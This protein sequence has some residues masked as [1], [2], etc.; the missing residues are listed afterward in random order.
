MGWRA[1]P[2]SNSGHR[3]AGLAPGFEVLWLGLFGLG[4]VSPGSLYLS[5]PWQYPLGGGAEVGSVWLGHGL[6]SGGVH[7]ALRQSRDLGSI[8]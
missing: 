2:S 1:Y 7:L 8:P 3:P 5:T 6:G 4:Q